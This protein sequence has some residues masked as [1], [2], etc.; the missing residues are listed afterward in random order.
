MTRRSAKLGLFALVVTAVV[1]FAAFKGQKAYANG[2]WG[3][4]HR[5]AIMKRMVTAHIDEV[6]ADAKVTDAQRQTINAAR[7]RVFTAFENQHGT[8]QAHLDEALQLF[9]SDRV[10]SD[11]LNGLRTRREAETRQLADTVTQAIVEIHDVL[12]PQQR[13]VVTDHIRSFRSGH[14]D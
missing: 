9:E 2:G 11:K 10:D 13:R 6:L 3:H 12:T 7:D 4:G 5:A 8:H 14:S 1:G